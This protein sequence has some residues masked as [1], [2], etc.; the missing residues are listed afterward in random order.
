MPQVEI[1]AYTLS[2]LKR[3]GE[4][5]VDTY[6]SIINKWGDAFEA[7]NKP[8]VDQV[9]PSEIVEDTATATK[10]DPNSP[11][12]LTFTK[13][14]SAKLDGIP[15]A[16]G[17]NWAGLLRWAI[18]RAK[19]HAKNTDDLHRLIIVNFAVGKREGEGFEY[20]PEADLSVQGQ[21]AN[22]A[23]RCINHIAQQLKLP[24]DIVFVWRQKPK[25]AFPGE[26][27]RLVVTPQPVDLR[28]GKILDL[29]SI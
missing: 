21:D 9:K 13:I 22:D 12:N 14:L 29:E 2:R 8:S 4:P 6:D 10:Y 16:K 5:W 27:G 11:P 28:L 15:L 3:F 24:V 7:H 19:Q 18:R 1:S 26:T 20:L 25:A 23:W 17:A